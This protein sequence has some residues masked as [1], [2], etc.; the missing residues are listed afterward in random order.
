MT[1]ELILWGR[2]FHFN[3]QLTDRVGL[4]SQL[5]VGISCVCFLNT[6]I[7]SIRC[8]TWVLG[9]WTPALYLCGKWFNLLG[10]NSLH[11]SLPVRKELFL[12]INT[13]KSIGC[14]W[15]GERILIPIYQYIYIG[16]KSKNIVRCE[17]LKVKMDKNNVMK[18]VSQH[19]GRHT[20]RP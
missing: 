14:P 6:G 17:K 3:Q 2:L 4:C 16:I 18:S 15:N 7:I 1:L 10:F 20:E 11:Q 13:G 19:W 12:K 5:A 8:P 9:I